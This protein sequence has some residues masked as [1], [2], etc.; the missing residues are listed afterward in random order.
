MNCSTDEFMQYIE[1]ED[2]KFV[3]LQFCDVFGVP[4]NISVMP[5][6][7]KRALTSGIGINPKGINGFGQEALSD[8][9]LHPEPETSALLPWLLWI[10]MRQKEEI[11]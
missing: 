10:R 9:F 8:L 4:K 1:E 6:D 2:I 7:I 3:R 5:G 11:G